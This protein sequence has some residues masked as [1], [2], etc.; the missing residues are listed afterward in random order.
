MAFGQLVVGFTSDMV[1]DVDVE[2]ESS[3]ALSVVNGYEPSS[4]SHNSSTGSSP[5]PAKEPAEDAVE[6]CQCPF[7]TCSVCGSF[8]EPGSYCPQ[9]CD[10]IILA[11]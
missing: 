6:S 3:L 10:V 11:D 7:P 4:P 9:L 8:I 2:V 1:D 5:E